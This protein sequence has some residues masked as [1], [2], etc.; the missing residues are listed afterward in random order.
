MVRIATLSAAHNRVES[1]CAA[2]HTLNNQCFKKEVHLTHF[3]VDDGSTDNTTKQL[4]DL[5][6]NTVVF[7]G[8]GQLYWAGAMRHGFKQ[9]RPDAYDFL[10]LFND[11][12]EFFKNALQLLL[13]THSIVSETEKKNAVIVGS[14]CSKITKEPTYGGRTSINKSLF[15]LSSR[16]SKPSATPISVY[17]L[18]MNGALI[19]KEI[20]N[21][22]GFFADYFRHGGADWEFGLRLRKNHIGLYQAPNLIGF[23][24]KN[25]TMNTSREKGISCLERMRRVC[26]IKENPIYPRYRFAREYSGFLWPIS[27]MQ[28]Y[29]QAF[30]CC[31]KLN[32]EL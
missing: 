11:D 25:S 10:F 19:P 8:S 15:P 29:V 9:I 3:I 4:R 5:F 31:F 20:L 13:D 16:L 17:T 18:N 6:S 12:C 2:I 1:T 26:S 27:F 28:P 7:E 32:K 23:C 22:I 21:K 24:E 30:L 14:F